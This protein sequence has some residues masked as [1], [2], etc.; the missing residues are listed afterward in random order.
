MPEM[1]K[2]HC[3]SCNAKLGYHGD[4]QSLRCPKCKT[5][6][7]LAAP[8]PA[9]EALPPERIESEIESKGNGRWQRW[10]TIGSIVVAIA[11][12]LGLLTVLLWKD[13][14]P[15][16]TLAKRVE[17]SSSPQST[18]VNTEQPSPDTPTVV[19]ESLRSD[20]KPIF[21]PESE[22]LDTEASAD[23]PPLPRPLVRQKQAV[24]ERQ[25]AEPQRSKPIDATPV[26]IQQPPETRLSHGNGGDEVLPSTF[27]YRWNPGD[28]HSYS[29][30]IS[31][32]FDG[33]VQSTTGTCDYQVG[34][35]TEAVDQEDLQG[36]GTGFVV[37]SNGYLVTC[38]HV[39]RDAAKIEVELGDQKWPGRVVAANKQHDLALIR[40]EANDLPALQLGKA[41]SI[42]LGRSVFVIGYPLSPLL[43]RSIKMSSGSVTGA[44]DTL[45][46]ESRR[47]QVDATVNPGNSGGPLVNDR[48]EVVGVAS[49][50]LASAQLAD[51]GFAV[52]ID[53]VR[54]MLSEAKVATA[55]ESRSEA[56][57]GTQLAK[58]VTPAVARINV[59][60][61]SASRQAY[62]ITY[63]ATVLSD[64]PMHMLQFWARDRPLVSSAFPVQLGPRQNNGSFSVTKFGAISNFKG[65]LMLPGLLDQA[66]TL[67]IESLD[68]E[69]ERKWNQTRF[70]SL[71]FES[72]SRF[73]M[74]HSF[75]HMGRHNPFPEL[76]PK[77]ES[78]P[79]LETKTYSVVNETDKQ[80]TLENTYE[81]RT[82]SDKQGEQLQQKGSGT[83]VF[84]KSLG[85][86]ESI[87]LTRKVGDDLDDASSKAVEITLN[88]KRLSTAELVQQRGSQLAKQFTRGVGFG[89]AKD[90]EQKLN[91]RKKRQ[92]SFSTQVS[93]RRLTAEQIDEMLT[94][95]KQS[96]EDSVRD[97]LP[98]AEVVRIL[99]QLAHTEVLP[100]KRKA[101][102]GMLIKYATQSHSMEKSSAINGLAIWSTKRE[103]PTIIRLLNEDESETDWNDKDGLIQ[104]LKPFPSKTVFKAIAA[105]L[106][107]F[108]VDNDA[109]DALIHFGPAAQEVV[110]DVLGSHSEDV[111][112]NA[113]KVLEKIG[114]RRSL[115]ALKR[116]LE[117]ENDHFL[118]RDIRRA[119][120]KINAR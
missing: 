53:E 20:P 71:Q 38:A 94:K 14:E 15:P 23:K 80:L 102:A 50:L 116:A 81:F 70:S 58:L 105:Q 86:P 67:I 6:F 111:R 9:A 107:E 40:I 79:A 13:P 24:E 88:C 5:R 90:T 63:S 104:A 61:D 42:E 109:V 29:F 65:S 47:F 69:G 106:G 95:L 62:P 32:E 93:H 83:I 27:G 92:Q 48:G 74:P 89:I 56:L 68:D 119:I 101:V 96:H 73:P 115:S 45:P 113:V 10:A 84:S 91:P 34:T 1:Q 99:S 78:Y 110:C 35:P 52:P 82:L 43:G 87:V 18:S 103:V 26:A 11:S 33:D 98:R 72:R 8:S 97:R 36:S 51:V 55:A 16:N 19:S 120:A 46:D 59:T 66:G 17:Q 31:A 39:V 112:E 2:V 100:E 64:P 30:E 3:P 4:R 118:Q 49:E 37:S 85:V 12:T 41:A 57:R 60:A 7:A 28:R 114:T 44:V 117:V 54:R 25:L 76:E 75:R 108:G 77:V 21:S 22:T